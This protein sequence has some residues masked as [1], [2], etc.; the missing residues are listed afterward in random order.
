MLGL[1][2]TT[3]LLAQAVPTPMAL[4]PEAIAL[5]APVGEAIEAERKAQA[6][7]PPPANDAER[8]ERM[9]RL[10]QVGRK[11]MIPIDLHTLKPPELYAAQTAIWTPIMAVDKANQEQLLAMVPPEGW[12]YKSRYGAKASIAAFLIVQHSDPTLWRRFVPVLEPLVATGEVRG[13]EYALMYDRL[14][15][16]EGRAQR[17][18]SQMTCKAGKFVVDKLEAPETVDERRKAMGFP[19]TLAEY[20]KHFENYPPC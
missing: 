15:L 9:A 20:A 11:A 13:P 10:E 19:N 16:S 2:L 17:Y 6:A 8:L 3:M 4:S 14:A 7:L 12:F 1:L 5:V 18:G